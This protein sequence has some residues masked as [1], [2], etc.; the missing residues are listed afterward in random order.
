LGGKVE[1][2]LKNKSKYVFIKPSSL[3]TLAYGRAIVLKA[4]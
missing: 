3:F 1:K 4:K 2:K